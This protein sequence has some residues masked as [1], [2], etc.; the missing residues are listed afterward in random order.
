MNPGR[1]QR[2]SRN[3]GKWLASAACLAIFIIPCVGEWSWTRPVLLP[4]AIIAAV[5]VLCMWFAGAA[6]R[7][8]RGLKTGA[9]IIFGLTLILWIISVL[10]LHFRLG[11][12]SLFILGRGSIELSLYTGSSA[13]VATAMTQY[14]RGFPLGWSHRWARTWRDIPMLALTGL[15]LPEFWYRGDA[16]PHMQFTLIHFPLWLPIV[17]VGIPAAWLIYKDS[18]RQPPGHCRSCGY[19]LT[20]NVSGICPECGTTIAA[21]PK[22]GAR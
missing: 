3:I 12:N 4:F 5:P 8:R 15:Y 19:D 17:L 14:G 11:T 20:G 6:A 9:W 2:S 13:E 16:G 18:R 10:G 1:D 21:C 22:D 7:W